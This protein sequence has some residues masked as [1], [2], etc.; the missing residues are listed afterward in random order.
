MRDEEILREFISWY[1][2]KEML[3]QEI[4][5]KVND[6]HLFDLNLDNITDTELLDSLNTI[7]SGFNGSVKA[8]LLDE[9]KNAVQF[10]QK[11]VDRDH[12]LH[13]VEI[14]IPVLQGKNIRHT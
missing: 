9:N 2:G 5:N 4:I 12:L 6:I 7:L 14:R 1:N 10:L 8:R 11:Y 3:L 13:W